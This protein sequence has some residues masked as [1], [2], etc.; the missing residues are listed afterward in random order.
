MHQ[1]GSKERDNRSKMARGWYV[2]RVQLSK[3]TEVCTSL[4]EGARAANLEDKIHAA[5]FVPRY[6]GYVIVE[7]DLDSRVRV[8]L[9]SVPGITIDPEP[10]QLAPQE[11]ENLRRMLA[12]LPAL[13]EVRMEL[14]EIKIAD[15]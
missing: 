14:S 1:V 13:P 6:R 11:V 7:M 8:F 15:R 4:L 5:R 9:E 12:G 2:F 3:E 10:T